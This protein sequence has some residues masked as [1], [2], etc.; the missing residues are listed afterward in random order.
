[1][2]HVVRRCYTPPRIHDFMQTCF[3]YV[4]DRVLHGVEEFWQPPE[5]THALRKGD[6][7]DWAIYARHVLSHHGLPARI[8]AAFDAAE[9]HA[10]CLVAWRG[11]WVRLGT[12]GFRALE[13]DVGASD[14][15]LAH[16]AAESF[17]PGRWECCSFVERFEPGPASDRGAPSLVPQYEWIHP[18]EFT[19][20]P[21]SGTPG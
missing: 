6:C 7:E 2:E 16:A 17:Y 9:G 3:E 11:Q 1:M 15:V 18:G 19:A 8:F 13:V 5:L 10:T 14:P 4:E 21:E 12:R 20:P